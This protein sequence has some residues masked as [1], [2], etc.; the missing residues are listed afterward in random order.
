MTD[1][2]IAASTERAPEPNAD[3]ADELHNIIVFCDGNPERLHPSYVRRVAA[4]AAPAAAPAGE[5]LTTERIEALYEREMGQT[6]RP[7][8]RPAVFALRVLLRQSAEPPLRS[9]R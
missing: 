5:P 9:S 2:K 6:L 3:L 4:L 7:Q 8:D 1:T